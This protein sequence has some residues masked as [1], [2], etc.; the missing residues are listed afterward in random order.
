MVRTTR[1]PEVV[2]LSVSNWIAMF[3]LLAVLVGAAWKFTID[4]SGEIR[5]LQSQMQGF[6]QRLRTLEK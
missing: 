3:A 6:E 4:I 5:S 1:D 2:Q